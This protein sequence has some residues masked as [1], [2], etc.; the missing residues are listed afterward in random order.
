MT[1]TIRKKKSNPLAP[2]SLAELQAITWLFLIVFLGG[3]VSSEVMQPTKRP[4][5]SP[6]IPG[7]SEIVVPRDTF[8][9]PGKN[10]TPSLTPIPPTNISP[11]YTF[12][13]TFSPAEEEA[14][15]IG[16]INTNGGCELPCWW[17]V[18]PGKSEEKDL[19]VLYRPWGLEKWYPQLTSDLLATQEYPLHVNQYKS[20]N[21]SLTA[22]TQS[23]VIQ[24]I[25]ILADNLKKFPDY[26]AAMQRYS[27]SNVFLRY[28]KPSRIL[29]NIERPIEVNAPRLYSLWVFYD[30]EGF[31]IIYAGEGWTENNY[32]VHICP[33]FKDVNNIRF[34]LQA[35]ESKIPLEDLVEVGLS[36]IVLDY[37]IEK[38]TNL[39]LGEFYSDV[40]N[41]NRQACFESPIEAWP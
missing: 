26:S 4:V 33:S 22:Y 17:G 3:C 5:I 12:G 16:L 28:G 25:Y 38:K 21:L 29:L 37:T 36:Q 35:S 1:S 13:P 30:Q 6:P 18:S 8:Q 27:F 15:W 19:L 24:R 41:T 9:A 10:L 11:T 23:G 31:L 34:Y 2:V 7:I 14:Y 20:L 32:F 39:S 40:T